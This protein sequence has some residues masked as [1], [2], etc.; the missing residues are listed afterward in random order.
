MIASFESDAH[1]ITR[2]NYFNM[3]KLAVKMLIESSVGLARALTD[4]H[5][6]L[7]QVRRSL[8]P[9][10]ALNHYTL[11]LLSLIET[12]LRHGLKIKKSVI[13]PNKDLWGFIEA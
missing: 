9:S 8:P 4:D 12:V 5:P 11:Q 3:V 7:K 13:G 2:T 1:A 10:S 6:Q